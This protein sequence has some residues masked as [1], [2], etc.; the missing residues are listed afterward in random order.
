MFRTLFCTL[1]LAVITDM[2]ALPDNGVLHP[3]ST[4]SA[5][6]ATSLSALDIL[7]RGIT[8]L[9]GKDAIMALKGVSLHARSAHLLSLLPCARSIDNLAISL[10]RTQSLEE[11]VTPGFADNTIATAGFQTI[12]YNLSGGLED[13]VQRIDR[14]YMISEYW[15]FGRPN[16]EPMNASIVTRGGSN[17]YSCYIRGNEGLYTPPLLPGGYTDRK[18]YRL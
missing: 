16:L 13:I 8:A 6:P 5:A 10:Y 1:A 12:S 2:A 4:V 18:Y 11:S 3:Y 9:G 7:A 17:G 14:Q 15:Y